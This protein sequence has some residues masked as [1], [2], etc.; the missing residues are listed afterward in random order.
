MSDTPRVYKICPRAAWHE[1][2]R[3]GHLTGSA[4]DLRDGFIHLSTR[5][6]LAGTAAK[7]FRH[8]PDL[9]LIALDAGRLGLALRWEPSRGGALFPHLY[10]RLD[11]AAALWVRALMLDANGFPI[12]PEDHDG[13]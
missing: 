12:I 2:T 11:V 4:D 9:V 3:L 1:A 6:Q 8:Q 10:G 13:C 7:H 5:E